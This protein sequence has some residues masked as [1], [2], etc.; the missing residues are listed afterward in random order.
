M[1]QILDIT[2][3]K[4]QL[5]IFGVGGQIIKY[6]N[7]YP[8]LYALLKDNKRIPEIVANLNMNATI[9]KVEVCEK[10]LP[11]GYQIEKQKML[12]IYTND[13][14]N[15]RFLRDEVKRFPGIADIFE[16]DILYKN[17]FIIDKGIGGM[18]YI[19]NCCNN[20]H[21][22][23]NEELKILSIDFEML[24]PDS[25]KMPEA[26]NDQI[27]MASL[28]FS[29]TYQKNETMVLVAS[30]NV[31]MANDVIGF[32]GETTL[33]R[34][35]TEIVRDYN[36]D[37]II[38]YNIDEFD[39]P[40]VA[41]RYAQNG[42]DCRW[43][44]NESMIYIKTLAMSKQTQIT[45]RVVLDLLP[46]IRKNY[47]YQ[48]YTLRTV[49]HE[50]LKWDKIDLDIRDMKKFWLEN[51]VESITKVVDYARR[52]AHLVLKLLEKTKLLDRFIAIS[53]KTGLLLQD[54]INGGQTGKIDMLIMKK[55]ILQNRVIAMKPEIEGSLEDE[56]VKYEGAIILTPKKGYLKD[57]VVV[58]YRSLYPTIMISQNYSPDTIILDNKFM[59]VPNHKAVVGGTFVNRDV[60]IGVVP[61]ILLELLNER[62][63]I[64]KDM[65]KLDKESDE[66]VYLDAKQ[67]AIKIL[68][69]SFYGYTGY[70]R[71]RLY[72]LDIASAVTSFGRK[73]ILDTKEMINTLGKLI[74]RDGKIFTK[75]E[76][77]E[78]D[79]NDDTLKFVGVN[80]VYGDTDSLFIECKQDFCNYGAMNLDDIKAIGEKIAE[81]ATKRLPEPMA[82][83]YEKIAKRI[84][85]EQKKKYAML[86]YDL[87][88]GEWKKEIATSG[89]ETKRRDWSPRVGETLKACITQVLEY[90]NIDEAVNIAAKTIK[91]IINLSKFNCI[92]DVK[93]LIIT[94]KYTKSSNLYKVEQVHIK[95]A[96]KMMARG[97]NLTL[98][99]RIQ[100]LI[101]TGSAEKASDRADTP[102]YILANGLKIDTRYYVEKQFFQPLKRFLNCFGVLDNEI[103]IDAPRVR[104]KHSKPETINSHKQLSL[105]NFEV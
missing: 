38:G 46:L 51:T 71:S 34:Y 88:K 43:G 44:R 36:P 50:L 26:T 2:S 3:R 30:K 25:G 49:S 37:I 19:D 31:P 77:G 80:V 41:A 84:V 45:G 100:Y 60:Q 35:L 53:K 68:L 39:F 12:R 102:E 66:Y 76:I 75:D 105:F 55:F 65:K 73:N 94:R 79:Y 93:D 61:E 74:I 72:I 83:L 96:K 90:D 8:Y 67:Y 16:A 81:I 20:L 22:D 28:A 9:T 54:C 99:D 21:Y 78:I 4:N 33:L 87:V 42:I 11:L 69:N 104:R 64:K 89:M 40:Y 5:E 98:G 13:P 27:I 58:D 91:E 17:R 7:F 18:Q 56:E 14:K 95:V 29:P 52:D 24:P 1:M 85:F 103:W 57:V 59:N 15:I 92:D 32:R 62:M 86:R 101:Y 23:K 63:A 70:T 97:I 6:N 48:N 10:F 82:L 47:S